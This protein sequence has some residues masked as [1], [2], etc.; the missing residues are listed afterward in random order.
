MAR[1]K[2]AITVISSAAAAGR[3]ADNMQLA[4]DG[5]AFQKRDKTWFL[6]RLDGIPGPAFRLVN[7]YGKLVLAAAATRPLDRRLVRDIQAACDWIH[8]HRPAVDARWRAVFGPDKPPPATL[9]IRV[10]TTAGN[11][12]LEKK[13]AELPAEVCLQIFAL[14]GELVLSREEKPLGADREYLSHPQLAP[15]LLEARYA[16]SEALRPDLTRDSYDW[17]SF[18]EYL[19]V[20]TYALLVAAVSSLTVICSGLAETKRRGQPSPGSDAFRLRDDLLRVL[21]VFAERLSKG[22]LGVE[23]RR[24]R[25]ALQNVA[26]LI[27]KFYGSPGGFDAGAHVAWAWDRT[28]P[29]EFHRLLCSGTAGTKPPPVETMLDGLSARS[30]EILSDANFGLASAT[31][32]GQSFDQV[33]IHPGGLG[34][35]LDHEYLRGVQVRAVS[36]HRI[37]LDMIG[38][39]DRFA[40]FTM[41]SLV[42]GICP[43]QESQ[44]EFAAWF[45]GPEKHRDF[46]EGSRLRH[47][48]VIEDPGRL[49]RRGK[50]RGAALDMAASQEPLIIDALARLLAR[51]RKSSR[52]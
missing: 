21:G 32:I 30:Q 14:Q 15:L 25:R 43:E 22:K 8:A 51:P 26:G 49:S 3:A 34:S 38:V 4:A 18:S 6:G 40:V 5:Q 17:R 7:E 19:V 50:K 41:L 23:D 44:Q 27:S 46:L 1:K 35:H 10:V 48:A 9:T 20:R 36:A 42:I 52:D 11:T 45:D 31:Y 33:Q 29:Q 37:L 2:A 47:L 12:G 28:V 13:L 24:T 39:A 16:A